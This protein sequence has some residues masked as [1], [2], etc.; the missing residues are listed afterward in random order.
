MKKA[1]RSIKPIAL[2]L[3]LAL[4]LGF[5]SACGSV[6]AAKES[7][8]LTHL[9]DY[10]W[11]TPGASSEQ[12]ST[13]QAIDLLKGYDV[14]VFGELHEHSGIHLAQM[15][16][17]GGLYQHNAKLSLSLEQFERDTQSLINQYLAGE[18]G[19]EYFIKKAR[20]W[21][22][23]RASYRPLMEF[24]KQ[25]DIPVIAAN[26]P[27]QVVTCVGRSGL[28]ILQKYSEKE[29]QHVAHSVDVADGPYRQK[30]FGFM[31]KDYA[32]KVPE[33]E[34][35]K[36]IMQTMS[37]RSFAAQAL[38]DDTMAESIA[39][40]LQFHPE[41]QV[42]HLNG[43][44]HSSGFLGVPE[45]LQS[46]MPE[47]KIAVINIMTEHDEPGLEPLGTLNLKVQGIPDKFVSDKNRNEWLSNVMKKRMKSRK[48]CP[49]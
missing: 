9:Y 11:L 21:D 16:L 12:I 49:Q 41:R 19:E 27:K 15:Q 22:N 30:F 45:R 33:D 24:A 3:G 47:L 4:A 10:Q 23:Y 29:R 48:R 44:F 7:T 17:M 2:A 18:I 26:A 39:L 1:T 6:P 34:A 8:S 5:I 40:H 14:I 36:K 38:R 42:I 32:H 25:R 28:D 31:N 37:E 13:E 43:N 35:S 20:A 46:R